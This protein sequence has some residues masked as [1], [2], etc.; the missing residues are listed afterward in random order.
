VK[1]RAE[2]VPRGSLRG[3]SSLRQVVL[4][5][6]TKFGAGRTSTDRHE[7]FF[8]KGVRGAPNLSRS[9]VNVRL[10][11]FCNQTDPLPTANR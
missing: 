1:I 6:T 5:S 9:P 3:S 11:R 4:S 8:L 2:G 7:P 10:R